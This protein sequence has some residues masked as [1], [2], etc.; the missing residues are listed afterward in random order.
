MILSLTFANKYFLPQHSLQCAVNEFNFLKKKLCFKKA[1]PANNLKKYNKNAK[2]KDNEI[3]AIAEDIYDQTDR[4]GLCKENQTSTKRLKNSLRAFTFNILD[5]DD[6]NVY[7]D[8]KKLKVIK[9]LRKDVA[10]LKPDKGNG[11][12]LINNVDYYQSLE[13]LFIDKKKFKQ[14]DKDPTMTQLSKLQSY[15]RS[16]LKRGELTEKQYKNLHPQ[17]SRAGR[18][19]TLP[20]I[21]KNFTVLPIFRPIVDM[22]SACHYYLT[23]LL[24]PLTQNEFIIRDSFDAANKIKSILPKVFNDGYIFASF[25]VESLFTNVPL[26]RT[27]NIILDRVYNNKLVATQL[28]KPTLKKL[29]KDTCSKIVFSANN[30]LY[31][32]TDGV[33]IGSSLGLLLVNII[34][35]EMEKAIIKKFVDEGFYYFMGVMSTT[36]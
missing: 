9:N 11:V 31:Q 10:I 12:V 27:I 28:K 13:D 2:P 19:H 1:F 26:Q 36:H 8:F 3:F 18:A 17:N 6:K 14:I 5:I 25:N 30:K 32:Q 35:T 33:S 4:K 34:M 20:K 7:L 24:N 15:L 21:H 22:T 29:I 16:L 23:E